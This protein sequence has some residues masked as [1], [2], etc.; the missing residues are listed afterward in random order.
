MRPYDKPIPESQRQLR[1]LE[2]VK[3]RCAG[4]SYR[5]IGAALGVDQHTAWDDVWRHWGQLR[6]IA[7]EKLEE[8]RARDLVMLDRM[9][10]RLF[11]VVDKAGDEQDLNAIKAATAAVK[12][13]ERR[14]K[15]MGSD[16][17]T[18]VQEVS[19]D[20]VDKMTPAEKLAAHEAAVAELKTQIEGNGKAVH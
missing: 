14:A 13:M 19:G 8:A 10:A 12:L 7:V 18:K 17:P 2:A 9:L 1:T 16:A 4:K 3:L 15:L 5:E 20:E 6:K 11:E